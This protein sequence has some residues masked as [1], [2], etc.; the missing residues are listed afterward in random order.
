M[1]P[2]IARKTLYVYLLELTLIN[3]FLTHERWVLGHNTFLYV[4][5]IMCLFYQYNCQ[6]K[7]W[8]KNVQLLFILY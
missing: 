6:L 4:G 8:K 5:A 2:I 7:T 3:N 1:S